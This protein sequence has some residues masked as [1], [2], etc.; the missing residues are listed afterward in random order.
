MTPK[1]FT[2]LFTKI[3][4]PGK[5]NVFSIAE[6]HTPTSLSHF[7]LEFLSIAITA[8]NS[9]EISNNQQRQHLEKPE[10]VLIATINR[11]SIV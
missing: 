9:E 3:C 5:A 2:S 7:M 11:G 10:P 8:I 1:H 4:D 6:P